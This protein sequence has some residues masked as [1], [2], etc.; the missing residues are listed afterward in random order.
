MINI[1]ILIDNQCFA[2]SCVPQ[3]QITKNLTFDLTKGCNLHKAIFLLQD[4]HIAIL[5]SPL[6]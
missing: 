2:L 4:G 5:R 6:F 3:A 1:T